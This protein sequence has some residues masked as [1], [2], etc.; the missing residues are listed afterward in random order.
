MLF[1]ISLFIILGFILV[2]VPNMESAA[3]APFFAPNKGWT[4]VFY[5]AAV[6]TV[7][8]VSNFYPFKEALNE[9]LSREEIIE[10]IDI[11]GPTLVRS[12]AK[13]ALRHGMVAPVVDPGDYGK[14]VREM[15]ENNDRLGEYMLTSLAHKAFTYT[16]EYEEEIKGWTGELLKEI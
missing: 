2:G 9:K 4:D 7:N 1:L 11:G 10:K 14:V 6:I 13:S 5:M 12:A 15:T 16:Q 3:H 8:F